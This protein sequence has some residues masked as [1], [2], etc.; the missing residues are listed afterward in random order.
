MLGLSRL[1]ENHQLG[2]LV[3]KHGLFC[4]DPRLQIEHCLGV[5]G[6]GNG[7]DQTLQ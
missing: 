3:L 7:I 4:S 1:V 5:G 6:R 2:V